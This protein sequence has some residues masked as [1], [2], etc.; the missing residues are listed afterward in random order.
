[1]RKVEEEAAWFDK[2]FFKTAPS[3]NEAV[4][5]GSP[6][7]EALKEKN[8]ART[9]GDYG[10]SYAVKGKSLLIPEVVKRDELEV[11]R[12][13][14]TRAQFAAF[15]KSYKVEAGT[16]NYPANGVS[17]E[18]A[19][20]YAE[21]LSQLTGQTWR[22]PTENEL[23]V[24]YD[25]KDGENTLDYWAGYPL[26]PDDAKRLREK[27]KELNGRAP[28][29]KPVGSFAG[30]GQE[31]EEPVFDVGGNA[32]EWVL[33]ADGKGKAAGGSADCPVD[34]RSSCTPEATY[35]GF[36]VVR[37]AAKAKTSQ[38]PA[39]AKSAASKD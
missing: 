27:V 18:Q 6:L 38:T 2:Y 33:T 17:L 8:V 19:R 26:N 37:G 28:L 36:R 21:W 23:A 39:A 24:K 35:I 5:A 32:A 1:M 12:F 7:D 30:Q 16:E 15:D 10:T 34:A 25:K 4:K 29:L 9:G 3:E 13:E 11:G 22:V 20:A 14:V 31:K